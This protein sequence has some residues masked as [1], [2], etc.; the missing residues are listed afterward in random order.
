MITV[1]RNVLYGR[2]IHVKKWMLK[3][4]TTPQSKDGTCFFGT[5]HLSPCFFFLSKKESWPWMCWD[6]SGWKHALCTFE[7][8][9]I[10]YMAYNRIYTK[11]AVIF[12]LTQK[13]SGIIKNARLNA[14]LCAYYCQSRVVLRGIDWIGFLHF[15]FPRLP[16]LSPLNRVC[17]SVLLLM[18]PMIQ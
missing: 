17:M 5:V 10:I 7:I 9:Y 18:L 15:D 12:G 6:H 4:R 16:Y 14:S 3:F 8:E 13:L 2:I 11:E 1:C